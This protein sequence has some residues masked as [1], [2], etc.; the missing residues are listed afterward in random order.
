V[1]WPQIAEISL[2]GA[3]GCGRW[4]IELLLDE[5]EAEGSPYLYVVT[6]ACHQYT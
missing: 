1:V 6:Q 4:L 2:L 5:L 3:L